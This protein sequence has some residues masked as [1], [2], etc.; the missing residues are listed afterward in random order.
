MLSR[1]QIT[2]VVAVYILAAVAVVL[3]PKLVRLSQCCR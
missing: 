3:A 2:V 1:W